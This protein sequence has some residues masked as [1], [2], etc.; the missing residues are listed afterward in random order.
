L[1]AFVPAAT[2]LYC[3]LAAQDFGMIQI[4]LFDWVERPFSPQFR[5]SILVIFL[6]VGL[7]TALGAS[8]AES[9]SLLV[10]FQRHFDHISTGENHELCAVG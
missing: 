7:V 10:I 4:F 8:H 6:A 9:A 5:N 2:R 3:I 1:T